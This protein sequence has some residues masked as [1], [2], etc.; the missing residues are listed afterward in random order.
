LCTCTCMYIMCVC[1]YVHVCV[2]IEIC[3]CTLYTHVHTHVHII[4]MYILCML[5]FPMFVC[6]CTVAGRRAPPHRKTQKT[7]RGICNSAPPGA[8]APSII[9]L[10][11]HRLARPPEVPQGA[12][13]PSLRHLKS[14]PLGNKNL[15][16]RD[17]KCRNEGEDATYETSRQN[18]LESPPPPR[19]RLTYNSVAGRQW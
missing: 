18:T 1:M 3:V 16:G 9:L 19:P 11:T 15:S 10:L 12:S 8:V 4:Y 7:K 17:F 6:V 2:H 13:S 5:G 14:R